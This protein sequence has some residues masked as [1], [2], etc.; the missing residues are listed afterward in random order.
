MTQYQLDL[1]KPLYING[2]KSTRAFYNLVVSIRDVKL[3]K[4]GIKPHRA[5]RISDVKNYFGVKGNAEEVL[6]GLESMRGRDFNM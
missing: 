5:W 6:A 4:A 3:W 1:E 2:A